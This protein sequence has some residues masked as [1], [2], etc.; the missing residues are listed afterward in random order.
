MWH[1]P[2]LSVGPKPIALASYLANCLKE[3][4]L[5]RD[6]LGTVRECGQLCAAPQIYHLKLIGVLRIT[7][8]APVNLGHPGLNLKHMRRPSRLSDQEESL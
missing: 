7:L 5:T 4:F 6:S 3:E 8:R 1:C 2:N